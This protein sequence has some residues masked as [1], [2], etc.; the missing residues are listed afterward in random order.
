MASVSVVDEAAPSSTCVTRGQGPAPGSAEKEAWDPFGSD[1]RE[2]AFARLLSAANRPAGS[3]TT[4][5]ST[6]QPAAGPASSS[7]DPFASTGDGKENRGNA[8]SKLLASPSQPNGSSKGRSGPSS[9]KRKRP[10]VG[11]TLLSAAAAGGARAGGAGNAEA[12]TRFCECPVCGK[13]VLIEMCSK[14]L[15]T[16]CNGL[17]AT[18]PAATETAKSP[19][20]AAT[21]SRGASEP[22]PPATPPPSAL[23]AGSCRSVLASPPLEEGK[24]DDSRA[25]T[26]ARVA[27]DAPRGQGQQPSGDAASSSARAAASTFPAPAASPAFETAAAAAAAATAAAKPAASS[28]ARKLGRKRVAAAEAMTACPVCGKQIQADLCSLHLDTDCSGVTPSGGGLKEEVRDEVGSGNGGEADSGKAVPKKDV[29]SEAAGGLNA[30]AA[31]LTCPICLCVFEDAHSLPCSHRFCLECILGCFKSSKRQEC[32]L[33]K[34]PAWK[35][36]LTRDVSIQNII[37]AYRR[38]AA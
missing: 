8:L 32:P 7:W 24:G 9:A 30:L 16:E 22:I 29:G 1:C 11:S 2:D 10:A 33:C 27:E 25:R 3:S 15:D 5:A 31:E 37:A 19:L 13:R 18:P 28:R 36:D 6:S 14:H 12:L 26:A 34:I 21:E 4:T 20:S 17:D 35:R 23:A 38:M